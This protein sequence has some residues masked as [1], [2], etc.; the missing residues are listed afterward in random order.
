MIGRGPTSH[1]EPEVVSGNERH[2]AQGR[3]RVLQITPS[4]TPSIGGIETVVAELARELRAAGH[5]ADVAHLA[6]SNPMLVRDGDDGHVW[7]VPLRPH[8]LIGMAP[9]LR[10]LACN[11]DLLH[12]H[13]P[14]AMAISASVALFGCGKPAVLST[15]GG[16][17]H[18]R[19]LGAFKTL[20]RRWLLPLVLTHYR[21]VLAT[22]RSDRDAFAKS[23]SRVVLAENGVAVAKF[24]TVRRE[25]PLNVNKWIYW[26]RLSANKRLDLVIAYAVRARQAGFPVSLLICGRDFDGISDALHRQVAASGITDVVTFV[27]HLS[28]E[29]LLTELRERGLFV[30]ASEHEGFGLA[31]VEAMAAGLAIACRDMAP[32]NGFVRPSANGLL[33]EFDETDEDLDRLAELLRTGAEDAD[34]ISRRNREVAASYDWPSAAQRFLGFYRVALGAGANAERAGDE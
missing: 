14:Q 33:L 31:V 10:K 32:L 3:I 7:R 25:Q 15:H 19:R 18:T 2:R 11:Y 29:E 22:S 23:S 26:G 5:V 21:L 24:G 8:R 34:S 12:V 28:D 1:R 13:D 4:Y 20:H 30:T 6:T 9:D 27:E 17:D 16:F